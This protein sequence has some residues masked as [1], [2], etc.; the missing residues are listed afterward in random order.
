MKWFTCYPCQRLDDLD[1][2]R[3]VHKSL[4]SR[5]LF[6]GWQIK[7]NSLN[8]LDEYKQTAEMM[9]ALDSRRQLHTTD[10]V[11]VQA[12]SSCHSIINRFPARYTL[13][14]CRHLFYHLWM[15][16][17]IADYFLQVRAWSPDPS[18]P[19]FFFHNR[20]MTMRCGVADKMMGT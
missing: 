10:T 16:R 19:T 12:G 5:K 11:W 13:G 8:F 14:W 2:L 17:I 18:I 1:V 7:N 9:Y 15:T 6:W 3:C 20:C 4:M